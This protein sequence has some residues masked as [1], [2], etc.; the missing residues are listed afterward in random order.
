MK[1]NILLG[2]IALGAATAMTS[3]EN[4]PVDEFVELN[5]EFQQNISRANSEEEFHEMC[6]DYDNDVTKFL[7]SDYKLTPLD[8]EA[9]QTSFMA[10]NRA[11]LNTSE[12]ITGEVSSENLAEYSSYL[13]EHLDNVKTLGEFFFNN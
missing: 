11:A 1:R 10:A 7:H 9:I 3:C 12:R 6:V 2:I 13:A 5:Y 4:S 8:K